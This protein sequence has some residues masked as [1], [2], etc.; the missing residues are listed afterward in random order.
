[1]DAKQYHTVILAG[2]LHDIGKFLQR[3]SFGA[4]DVRGKH[5][6]VSVNFVRAFKA[7]FQDVADV[8][9]LIQ[10]VQRHHEDPRYPGHLQVQGADD[11]VRPLAY[12]VSRADNYSSSERGAF[13]TGRDYKAV[14]MASIFCRVQIGKE[15]P[16][17]QHYRLRTLDPGEAF[18]SIF[19]EYDE[20]EVNRHLEDFGREFSEAVRRVN[21]TRF[22]VLFTQFLAIFQKYIWCIPSNT[23]EEVPDVSLFDHLKSASAIAA[24]LYQYHQGGMEEAAVKRDEEEKFT[25]L[26]CD[27]SGIQKYIFD[28]TQI[29]TGGSAKR[30]RARSFSV[31]ILSDIVSHRVLGVFNLPPSN[32]LMASGGK[33]FCLLPRL[34]DVDERIEAIRKDFDAWASRE[35]NGELV[36]N[37]A[38]HHFSGKEFGRF[39]LPMERINE[40]LQKKKQRPLQAKVQSDGG[41]N[42]A[43]FLVELQFADEESLCKSC[44]KRPGT[45]DETEKEPFCSN[46]RRDVV[47]GRHLPRARYV[48]FYNEEDGGG[49]FSFGGARFSLLRNLGEIRGNPYLV[50]VI[51]RIGDYPPAH[52]VAVKYLAN[53]IPLA[54][55]DTCSD[56]PGSPQCEY[57]EDIRPDQPVFFNCIAQRAQ[58]AKEIAYLKA[59][60]DRLGLIFA[61]GLRGA[62]G[63]L[64]TVSRIATM[65]RMLDLF[66]SGWVH[67]AIERDFPSLYVVYSGGDDML[68]IGPWDDVVEFA[69]EL[70]E[71]FNRFVGGNPSITLSAGIVTGGPKKPVFQQ[72]AAVEE[73]LDKSKKEPARG[74][75][76]GRNQ[77]TAFGQ[78]F[79]WSKVKPLVEEGQQ[80]ARWLSDGVL[81]SGF[82]YNALGYAEMYERFEK[83]GDTECLRCIPLINYDIVRNLPRPD[84]RDPEKRAV[85]MWAERLKD[86]T[87]DHIHNLPFVAAYGLKARE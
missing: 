78:T 67:R 15:L 38:Y 85:R 24:C 86:V 56:C 54:E 32:I 8:D 40:E 10:L 41:W 60:V 53:Y 52:P 9:L 18:P 21:K 83:T 6:E 82:V 74:E 31:S 72:V 35:T 57:Q 84:D 63:G 71:S 7:V 3:G 46:C 44:R 75:E 43:S 33:F 62:E 81:S 22:D 34:P 50:G 30:L 68:V 48:A 14:P 70:R 77:L 29:G 28:I 36:V 80:I 19:E 4:L 20:G 61:R 1:M 45:S 25:L 59:D 73:A 69:L 39:H 42:E 64:N 11:S 12:L 47:V 5:P 2:L 76:T 66:F 55:A 79:K 87:R 23:Q 51:N 13:T 26:V 27:V 37:M 17:L 16:K 65:S 58:G 49:E